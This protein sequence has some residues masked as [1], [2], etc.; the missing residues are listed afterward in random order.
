MSVFRMIVVVEIIEN[1]LFGLDP[2]F[3]RIAK[4]EVSKC[5]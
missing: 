4:F 1:A 3:S 2:G 5:A